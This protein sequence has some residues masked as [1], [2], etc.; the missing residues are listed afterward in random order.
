MIQLKSKYYILLPN[1]MPVKLEKL[2]LK[3][4]KSAVGGLLSMEWVC[5]PLIS[6]K[7]L[8]PVCSIMIIPELFN[9]KIPLRTKFQSLSL[10][11]LKD[12][13]IK[14]HLI[15]F[16]KRRNCRCRDSVFFKFPS[17]SL[18]RKLMNMTPLFRFI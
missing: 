18:L 4:L 15:C 14:K 11:K 13:S 6:K 1:S 8:L 9:S 17:V 3:Q 10:W 16:S 5:L 12:C 7:R 2:S